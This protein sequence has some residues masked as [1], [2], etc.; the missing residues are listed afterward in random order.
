[1]I[2][3]D[4][5]KKYPDGK[6]GM[7][8]MKRKKKKSLQYKDRILFVHVALPPVSCNNVTINFAVCDCITKPSSSVGLRV[9]ISRNLRVLS[10][11]TVI[12]QII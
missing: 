8:N 11:R 10:G 12:L 4:Y 9:F 5:I 2:P 1:M 3:D 7:L 6:S